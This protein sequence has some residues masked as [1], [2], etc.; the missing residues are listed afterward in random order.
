[1][2]VIHRHSGPPGAFRWE[3]VRLERYDDPAVRAVTKQVLIG[4]A[5]GAT[6]FALRYFEVAPGA[7]SALDRH[8]H[9]HGVLVVKGRGRVR[10]GSARETIGVGDVIYVAPDEVHQFESLGP[11]PL[12]FLCVVPPKP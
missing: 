7:A 4:P 12:G 10:L 6:R 1:M 2:G 9:D 3:G 11:E 8:P 5:E